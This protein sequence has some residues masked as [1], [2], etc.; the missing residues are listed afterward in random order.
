M[1]AIEEMGLKSPWRRNG[2]KNRT[3]ENEGKNVMGICWFSAALLL[4]MTPLR[5]RK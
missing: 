1:E 4:A 3:R 2:K 5:I